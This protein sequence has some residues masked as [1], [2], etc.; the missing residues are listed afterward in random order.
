M[1]LQPRR[2]PKLLKQA[3]FTISG[4]IVNLELATGSNSPKTKE[5]IV[6]LN[7]RKERDGDVRRNKRRVDEKERQWEK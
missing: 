1:N 7:S 6:S 3:S 5:Q 2:H 4:L